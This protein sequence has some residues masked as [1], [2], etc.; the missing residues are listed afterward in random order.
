MSAAK[1]I[2]ISCAGIGSR[3]GLG[4]T[5]ALIKI[6]DRTIIAWQLELFKDIE[7]V[8]IVIG[9]QA[10]DVVKEVL[11]HRKDVIFVYNHEYYSTKTGASFYLG[12][13][14]ANEYVI[15]WDGD[16]LVHPDDVKMLLQE[17]GEFVGYS[18]I[19]SD[20][21]VYVQTDEKGNVVAFSRERGDYE[22]TGPACIK[23]DKLNYSSV[24]VFNQLEPYL[25]MKGLKIRAYDIDTYDDYKR[26]TEIVKSW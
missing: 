22:W 5:K 7:D 4:Q 25:P 6:N 19:T 1:S 2:V 11:R 13:R 21:A 18:D 17:Q 24:H 26:V 12:S 8:R 14:H 23:R 9:Y 10:K 3:L 15:E 20:E 16:M